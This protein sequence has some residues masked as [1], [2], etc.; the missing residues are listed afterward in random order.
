MDFPYAGGKLARFN[1]TAMDGKGPDAHNKP[2]YVK[3]S[4]DRAARLAA[5][6]ALVAGDKV[7][8]TATH[9]EAPTTLVL[10]GKYLGTSRIDS[11]IMVEVLFVGSMDGATKYVKGDATSGLIITVINIVGGTLM[12]V[13]RQGLPAMDALQQ[14]GILTIGDGLCS[15]IP[16]LL[17]SL[18]TGLGV[19]S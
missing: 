5:K 18:A 8:F 14:Y 1:E 15:Q 10:V 11:S 16:S 13:T 17:I 12:G 2:I 7:A 4:G 6:A 3:V 9:A 19:S